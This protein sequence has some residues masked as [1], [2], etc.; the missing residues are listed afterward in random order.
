MAVPLRFHE[1]VLGVMRIDHV[2]PGFF[3]N[4][5]VRLL[6]AVG[7]QAALAMRHTQ[8]QAQGR[9]LAVL[10]ERHR[11]AR[12]LH[13]A[14]S[15]TLFAAQVLAG[16]LLQMLRRPVPPDNAAVILQ[17]QSLERLNR[18]ALAEMRLL[19]FELRPDA[20]ENVPLAD[21]LQNTIDTMTT[22]GDLVVEKSL[23]RDVGFPPA[24]R[25]HLYRMA[26]EALSNLVRH[27]GATRASV[28]WK[29]YSP[30]AAELR[31]LDNGIGFQPDVDRPG[32][33][34]LGNMRSRAAEIGARLTIESRPG[35]GTE[36]LIQLGMP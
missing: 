15:Q 24:L 10:N 23:A 28:E 13:D 31:I 9:E 22:R 7:S 6:A 34:G 36:V 2:E 12:D 20:L 3:D 18:A 25:L 30:D 4:E 1:E 35:L 16:S 11:I 19:M 27:S 14:V 21:L 29:V 33:F 5:R 17:V 26:Q 32:H 8:L